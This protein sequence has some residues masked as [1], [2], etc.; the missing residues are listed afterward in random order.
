[1]RPAADLGGPTVTIQDMTHPPQRLTVPGRRHSHLGLGAAHRRLSLDGAVPYQE[2]KQRTDV[3]GVFPNPEA[4]LRLAGAVLVEA[5]DEWQVSDRRYLSEGSMVLLTATPREVT[6]TCGGP[7]VS[8]SCQKCGR[9]AGQVASR[10]RYI[11]PTGRERSRSFSR[12]VDA[13]RFLTT[14]ESVVE[15]KG[16]L[17]IG[18]PKTR[19]GRRTIGLPLAV[20]DELAIH[21]GHSAPSTPTCSPPTRA[22]PCGP[23]TSARRCG[24]LRSARLGWRRC[25]RTTFATPPW[26]CGSRLARTQRRSACGPATRRCRSRST[27]TATCR[28][29][30]PGA[31]RPAGHHAGRGAEGG[32]RQGVRDAASLGDLPRRRPRDDP[33]QPKQRRGPGVTPGPT[34]GFGGCAARDSNPEPLP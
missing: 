5:H 14:V 21:M 31:A 26:R 2:I 16:Q 12:K 10:A 11:D 25:A 22:Q 18:P 19:A 27:A 34:C 6:P 29:P 13:E 30:R 20:V 15:V 17:F 7:F 28:G 32:R 23:R 3:V 1:M 8:G 33:G 4:L 24:S 9:Q